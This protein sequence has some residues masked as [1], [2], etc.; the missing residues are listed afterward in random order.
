MREERTHGTESQ[1]RNRLPVDNPRIF[2]EMKIY[3]EEVYPQNSKPNK[4]GRTY[5]VRAKISIDNKNKAL[6]D[7]VIYRCNDT[8]HHRTG[9]KYKM[10]PTY[11]F[12]C[13]IVDSIEGVTHALRTLEYKDRDAQYAWML[14]ALNMRPVKVVGFS[15][16][17]FVRTVLSKRKLQWFVDQGFVSGWDD[18]R[19]PTVRGMNSIIARLIV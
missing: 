18:P 13:P 5:C 10:Y 9:D 14:K 16:M 11:D 17:N 1:S 4:K 3:S 8:I 19:F 6:R 2:N 12:A 15:R 7:P